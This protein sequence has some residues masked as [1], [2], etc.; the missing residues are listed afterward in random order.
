MQGRSFTIK[1]NLGRAFLVANRL[2]EARDQISASEPY[3]ETDYQKAQVYYYRA[4]AIEAIGN[5][6]TADKE[7]EKL[8]EL[9]PEAVPEEWIEAAQERLSPSPTPTVTKTPVP[10][11]HLLN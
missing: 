7:W 1:L 10:M 9:P 6:P 3:A 8:L 11:A 2:S 4:L 5:Q